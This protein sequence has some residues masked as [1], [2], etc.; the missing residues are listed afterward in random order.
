[1]GGM[2]GMGEMKKRLWA[3]GLGLWLGENATLNIRHPTPK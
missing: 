2:R 1:M 3:F